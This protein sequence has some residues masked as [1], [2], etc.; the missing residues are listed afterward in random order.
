MR[1]FAEKCKAV[2]PR[3]N[4]SYRSKRAGGPAEGFILSVKTFRSK[5][6]FYP[7]FRSKMQFYPT[8]RS[9]ML[10]YPTFR[11]GRDAVCFFKEDRLIL[12]EVNLATFP[13]TIFFNLIS[14][15]NDII[16]YH[17]LIF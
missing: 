15:Y 7:T 3:K 1:C 5:I 2:E 6:K 9:K 12:F 8:F 10:F 13:A 4:A 11:S 14:C 17:S 16:C